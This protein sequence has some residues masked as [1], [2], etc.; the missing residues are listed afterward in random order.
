LTFELSGAVSLG[1][2]GA[3]LLAVLAAGAVVA[4]AAG[5]RAAFV[6]VTTGTGTPQ[7]RL[8]PVVAAAL[9]GSLIAASVPGAVAGSVMAALGGAGGSAGNA[10]AVGAGG[11]W[12]GGYFLAALLIAAAGAWALANLAGVRVATATEPRPA[13]PARWWLPLTPWRLVRTPARRI[14]AAADA[15]DR[16]FVVQ[17]QL[18]LVVIAA[19]LAILLIR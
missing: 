14:D 12:A 3:A 8:S 18:P 15:V 17:P 19:L 9:T 5:V 6:H 4:A 16:W 1:R 10:V 13:G 2:A 7:R 11:G